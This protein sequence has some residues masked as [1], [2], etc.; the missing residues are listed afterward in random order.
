[1]I[2]AIG[3]IASLLTLT[4]WWLLGRQWRGAPVLH[5]LGG[6]LWAWV[7]YCSGLWSLLAVELIGALLALRAWRKWKH[8][9]GQP[10]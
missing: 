6:L 4:G 5:A 2:E 8:D 7:G 9:P 3:W 10:S 1:M